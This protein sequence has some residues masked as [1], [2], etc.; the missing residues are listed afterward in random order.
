MKSR[1][2]GIIFY[3]TDSKTVFTALWCSLIMKIENLLNIIRRRRK[4]RMGELPWQLHISPS[5]S[6]SCHSLEIQT[7]QKIGCLEEGLSLHGEIDGGVCFCFCVCVY[8]NV[9][10]PENVFWV[11]FGGETLLARFA[12]PEVIDEASIAA[13]T[14]SEQELPAV[15]DQ[16]RLVLTY[17]FIWF[18]VELEFYCNISLC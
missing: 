12:Q 15:E 6:C 9:I 4:R 14:I 13:P 7:W 8:V 11:D 10:L 2:W 5:P 16:C 3:I 1:T 17:S 18:W